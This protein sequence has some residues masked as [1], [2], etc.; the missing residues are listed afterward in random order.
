M[1]GTED[2][3]YLLASDAGYGFLCRLGDMQARNR[4][5]KLVLNVPKGARVLPPVRVRDAQRERA[6]AVTTDGYMLAVS[7]DELPRLNRG[8]GNKLINVPLARL[9]SR[10]EFVRAIVLVRGDEIITIVASVTRR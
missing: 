10:E 5:G 7:L 4:A 1:M 2:E 3:L 6:V 8:K 9:K